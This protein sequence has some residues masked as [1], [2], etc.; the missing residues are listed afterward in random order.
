MLFNRSLST[1]IFSGKCKLSFVTPIFKSGIGLSNYCG[2]AIL[3][4]IAMLFEL[5]VYRVMYDNLRGRL[6]DC[7]HG[8][9]KGR[10]TVSN[11][12]KYSSFVLKS[13]ED[14]CQVDSM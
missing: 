8:F 7:P 4:A 6:V 11:L 12:L 14:G 13:F 5:L 10:L 1:C 2:I 9:V 3:S